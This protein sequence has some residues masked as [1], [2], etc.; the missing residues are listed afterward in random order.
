MIIGHRLT[1]N[2]FLVF[3]SVAFWAW[4]WGALGA[5]LAV[6]LLISVV[7]A[8]KHLSSYLAVRAS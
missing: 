6:P 7:V 4:M 5:L 2:P 1:L 8:N 3:L